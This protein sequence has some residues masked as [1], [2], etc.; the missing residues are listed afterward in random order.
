[1]KKGLVKLRVSNICADIDF[2]MGG[3]KDPNLPP[4]LEAACVAMLTMTREL[5]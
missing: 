3:M 4:K 5:G 2:K 1:M